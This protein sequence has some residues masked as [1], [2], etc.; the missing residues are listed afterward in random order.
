M[1]LWMM[2]YLAGLAV[3]VIV[4]ALLIGILWQAIRIRRLAL[5]ASELVREIEENTRSV[6][7]LRETHAIAGTILTGATAID[8]N[9][10]AIIDAVSHPQYTPTQPGAQL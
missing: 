9:A 3:V 1:S 10:H 4:A 6:W 5:A 2:G 8:A 7:A